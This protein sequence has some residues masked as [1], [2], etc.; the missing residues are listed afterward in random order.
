[1]DA[2]QAINVT[3]LC[4]IAT[5]CVF[6]FFYIRLRVKGLFMGFRGLKTEADLA[7]IT[8]K[9]RIMKLI[10]TWLITPSKSQQ[11]A[12]GISKFM[13]ACGRESVNDVERL[14]R[15]GIQVNARRA[16]GGKTGLMVASQNGS[17]GVVQLLIRSGADVNAVGGRTGKSAL[18][19]AAAR[20][21]L[22]IV[23]ALLN[24]GAS[25]NATSKSSGK[26]PLMAA[27]ENGNLEVAAILLKAGADVNCRDRAGETAGDLA[28]KHRRAEIVELLRAFRALFPGDAD[29]V[30]RHPEAES[31]DRYYAVL[32]CK[33]TDSLDQVKAQYRRLI[34]QYH[35][36]VIQ[37]KGLSDDFLE[38]ANKKFGLIREAYQHIVKTNHPAQPEL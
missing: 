2:S 21:N 19:R 36:D 10:H 30:R 29:D 20:G 16:R 7:K 18:I 22:Q 17:I 11:K 37:G 38:L 1:M 9:S 23:N 25:I 32:G 3:L 35:P 27:V 12:D 26:T 24:A 31:I 6:A 4:G 14:L 15:M 13:G 33:K 34:K 8:K 28:V 5:F